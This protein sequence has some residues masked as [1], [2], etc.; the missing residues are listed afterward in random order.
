MADAHNL[1]MESRLVHVR[2]LKAEVARLKA[3]NLRLNSE[4]GALSSHFDFALLA[5]IDLRD[6][7]PEGRMFIFDGWNL[8][9]GAGHIAADR[10]SLA[11]EAR[12][13]LAANPGSKAWIVYDGKDE[14][15]KADGDLR[16]S[17]TGGEGAHRA[18]RLI[19]DY[20]RLAA[21][22]GL[23]DK[24]EVKTRD[25]DFLKTVSKIKGGRDAG[26]LR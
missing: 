24:V 26:V 17:Y 21:Y 5:A 25:R 15:V 13:M 4:L 12:R 23:A 11:A 3:E 18:D 9:L 2:E 6:L 7:P 16:I 8:I 1:M 22:L 10:Q 20:L 14:N 19:C